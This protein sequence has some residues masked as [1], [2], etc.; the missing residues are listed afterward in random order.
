L[1]DFHRRAQLPNNVL[2][3]QTSA[4]ITILYRHDR[5][6][7]FDR[8]RSVPHNPQSC[9]PFLGHKGTQVWELTE[10]ERAQTQQ[11]NGN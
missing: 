6:V 7:Q 8:A 5:N 1:I 4:L 11:W 9:R 10:T 3:S 2:L